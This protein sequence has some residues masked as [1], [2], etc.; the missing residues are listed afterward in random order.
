MFGNKKGVSTVK[1]A[2]LSVNVI[3]VSKEAQLERIN[4]LITN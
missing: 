3:I 4:R 1:L 2:A